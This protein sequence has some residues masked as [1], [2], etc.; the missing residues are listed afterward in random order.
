MAFKTIFYATL[1]EKRPFSRK[2]ALNVCK[3]NLKEIA[4]CPTV[5]Y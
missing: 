3:E 1:R 4:G 5:G 2:C